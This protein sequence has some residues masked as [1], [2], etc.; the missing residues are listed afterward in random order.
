V[1]DPVQKLAVV[2]NM[3]AN[4]RRRSVQRPGHFSKRIYPDQIAAVV[5]WTPR[6]DGR[7]LTRGAIDKTA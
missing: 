4:P 1:L 3:L 7:A 5:S 6:K 2:A